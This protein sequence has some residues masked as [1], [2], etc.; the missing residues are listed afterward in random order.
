MPDDV[1]TAIDESSDARPGPEDKDSLTDLIDALQRQSFT[2]RFTPA[3]P[4]ASDRDDEGAMQ[5]RLRNRPVRR[6]AG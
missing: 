5:A 1:A 4:P 3:E 6:S 2:R